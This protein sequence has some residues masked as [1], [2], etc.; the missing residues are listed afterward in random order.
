[1][2]ILETIIV[3]IWLIFF[4]KRSSAQGFFN[5]WI[6]GGEVSQAQWGKK[7]NI[8]LSLLLFLW[9]TLNWYFSSISVEVF[10]IY[11][12]Q[13]WSGPHSSMGRQNGE[14]LPHAD[15]WW[16]QARAPCQLLVWPRQKTRCSKVS[17]H[18]HNASFKNRAYMKSKTLQLCN[19][20]ISWPLWT[21]YFW[22]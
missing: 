1:M 7:A 17:Y 8:K 18:L 19:D 16:R 11:C 4:F 20:W 5:L 3:L 15:L 14:R 10:R 9:T 22:S 6:Q 13:K 21:E 12:S 2:L